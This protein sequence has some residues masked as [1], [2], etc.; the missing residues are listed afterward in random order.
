[1]YFHRTPVFAT[2]VADSSVA[3]DG[4]SRPSV[5]VARG[6]FFP[7]SRLRKSGSIVR[8]VSVGSNQNLQVDSGLRLQISGKL[9]K[10]VE[11]VAS[12]TD[13]NT[14]IQPEGNTQTLREID[15]VFVQVKSPKLLATL[16][17]YTLNL[18]GG[19]FTSY[20]R[21]LEG[22]MAQGDFDRLA[23]KVSAAVSRGQF[24]TNQFLGQEGKQG[25]YQLTAENGNI[26]ILVL[27][28]TEKVWIDGERMTRGENRDY[29]IEYGN[30]EM[31]PA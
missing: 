24:Q 9:T 5:P 2:P 26:N 27:A 23:F 20:E 25:P 7:A 21:K 18:A 31:V 29:T 19:R 30:V 12:L 13:Q 8:G 28:G 17:D 16:G 4:R 10:D 6:Q 3:S 11:V 1:N 15:K 22:V 14:P